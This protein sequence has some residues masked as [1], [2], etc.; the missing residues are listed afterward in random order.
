MKTLIF[1]TGFAD[2]LDSWE[3]RYSRWIN[4]VEQSRLEVDT[5]L[6]PDDGSPELPDWDGVEVIQGELPD[7]EPESRAVI[8]KHETHLGR[9]S[10]YVFPGWHR[11]FMVAIKYAKKYGYEKVIHLEADAF[12]ISKRVQSYVN[13]FEDGWEVFWCPKY[14]LPETSIQ[15]IA[16][17]SLN[18]Y[19]ELSTIPYSEFAGRPP[20]PNPSQ[21]ESWLK[22]TNINKDFKGDR[23]GEDGDA[24]MDSD[25]TCQTPHDVYCWWLK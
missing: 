21:G 5:L 6:I 2:N 19:E 3:S 16:G 4:A 17:G 22:F 15:L 25:Y 8:Y 24:P 12:L 14:Q 11:S 13:N 18:D 7:E 9:P 20:D 1:C 23:Y 10:L